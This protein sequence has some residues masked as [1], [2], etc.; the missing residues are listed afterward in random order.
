MM[1]TEMKL[2]LLLHGKNFREEFPL[3]STFFVATHISTTIPRAQS[4]GNSRNAQ[5]GAPRRRSCPFGGSD[6]IILPAA[7]RYLLLFQTKARHA[8]PVGLF[9]SQGSLSCRSPGHARP[10]H[11]FLSLYWMV[12]WKSDM[13]SGNLELG[14]W[15][16]HMLGSFMW[17]M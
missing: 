11:C 7:C 13:E 1:N 12:W 15:K 4:P 3:N 2:L 17:I 6:S 5:P 16:D 14:S 10:E 8:A 9:H